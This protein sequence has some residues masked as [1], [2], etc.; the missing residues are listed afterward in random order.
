MLVCTHA[1]KQ[2][3]SRRTRASR[4][5][6][7]AAAIFFLTEI[8]VREALAVYKAA[9][10]CPDELAAVL[11]GELDGDGKSQVSHGGG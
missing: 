1:A 6:S 9:D 11:I 2:R 4:V 10:G 3:W 7:T 5:P 8:F